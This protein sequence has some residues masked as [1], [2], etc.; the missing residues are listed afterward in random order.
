MVIALPKELRTTPEGKV[1]DNQG[2]QKAAEGSG[3]TA[4]EAYDYW[5]DIRRQDPYSRASEQ[6]SSTVLK[7]A[8]KVGV[9]DG[10]IVISAPQNVLD[11]PYVEQLSTQLKS[12]KGADLS[13][14]ETKNAIDALNKEIQANI[15]NAMIESSFGWDED[16]YK[17]YQYNLQ[18]LSVSNPLQSSNKI[19][20]YDKDN[21]IVM[22]TPQEWVDYYRSVYNTDERTDALYDSASSNDPYARTMFLV[23]TQGKD[24]PVY[25]W[26]FGEQFAQGTNAAWNQI[27]KLPE[28]L[29]RNLGTDTNT[30]DVEARAKDL[31]IPEEALKK[32]DVV[33]EA[34]FNERKEALKDKSWEELSDDDKAFL[35]LLGVSKQKDN[36]RKVDRDMMSE[37]YQDDVTKNLNNMSSDDVEV[38]K[39]AINGILSDNSFEDYR[40]TRNNYS[41]WSG[42]DE[43]LNKN[44]LRLA[45]NAVWSEASQG[46]GNMAG[47]IARFLWE[48]ALIRAATGGINVNAISDK[49]G[50]GIL[51][52]INKGL[53]KVGLPLASK[54][55][56]AIIRF[57]GNL[58]GTIPEDILQTSIDNVLTYN[59]DENKNLLNWDELSDDFKRTFVF[60]A[61]FNAA[62]AGMSAFKRARLAKQLAKQADLNATMDIDGIASDADDLARA[63][64]NGNQITTEDGV[65]SVTDADGNTTVFR[66]ITPEDVELTQKTL[67][68]MADETMDE[69]ARATDGVPRVEIDVETPDGTVKME[70]PD[71][72]PR[73]LSEALEID[74]EPTQAGVRHWHNR[75]LEAVM[76]QLEDNLNKFHDKFGDVQASDFDWVWYQTKQGLSPEQIIGTTDPA[77]G[78][79]V[80]KNT[81]N[82]IEWWGKQPFVK[83]L[84]MASREALSLDGD[85]NTLGYLPHTDYDPGNASFEEAISGQLWNKATGAS[86]LRDGEYVGYGGD[87]N[88]RYRTFASNMLW[89]AKNADVATAKLIEEAQM[90]GRDVTPELIDE[91][92]RAVSGEK[93]IQQK[94]V[95]A[96]SSKK[97]M[98]ALAS[99]SEDI[100]WSEID[101]NIEKQAKDSGLGKAYHDNYRDIYTNADTMEITHQR[102]GLVNSFD[103]L[104]N[105]MRNTVIGNGMSMYDWGGAD[106]VY[107]SKNAADI[108]NRFVREGGDF[109]GMLVDYVENHSHRTRKYAEAVVDKWMDKLGKIPGDLTK[110][111]VLQSLS[112]SMK[113][114]AMTRLKKWL[115]MAKY[116]NFNSSTKKMIDQFLFNHVQMDSIKTNPTIGQKITKALDQLTGLRYRALFYGNIKNALLQ[117]SELNRYFSAFKWGDVANMAKRLATDESFRARVDDYVDAVAPST[118][119]L[120]A[121]L[122][123]NFSNVADSMEVGENGV[124][125]RDLGKKMKT[126]A[127]AIGLG[128]IEA[129]ESFKN[130]MMIAGLVSEADRLELTGDEALRHIRKR[131][132]RVALAAD[133]MG[134]IGLASNPL[135]KTM[136][137]LQNFQIRELGMHLYNIKDAWNLGNSVP[138]KVINATNYLTK[139]FGAKL[140]T[141][142]ILARLGYSPAQTMG[143]DPFGLLDRYNTMDEEDMEWVDKQIAG[144]LLTPFFSGGMTS[145]IA[146]MYFMARQAYEDSHQR[147]VAEEAEQKLGSSWGLEMPEISFDDIV[148]GVTSFI[149][150]SV[151][152]NRFGQM[153]QM[154]DTGWAVSSTGNQMYSAPAD[155][156]NILLGY[157]FGRSATQNALQYNQNYGDNLLQTVGR[158]NPFR[159]YNEFD[160][161]DTKN[162]SDWFKGDENDLQQFN[163]GRI[164]FQQEKNNIL[165][166]YGS[167]I[168]NSYANDD[169]VAEAQNSMNQKLNELFDKVDRFVDAYEKK[170]GTMSPAMA[171]QIINLLNIGRG[172]TGETLE[173]RQAREL[174][175]Y[176][177]ALQRYSDI[178]FSPVGT[179]TGP[180]NFDENKE[181]KYQGSPQYRTA[182][183][184][185]YTLEDEAALVLKK[186][187]DKLK[188]VRDSIKD[189]LNAAYNDSDYNTVETIQREY[190]KE[191]DN[192][193]SPIIALYGNGIFESTDVV[194]Q[195]KDMLSTGTNT[196]S[197]NLI[198]SDQYRKDKYGKYRSM[199]LETVDVKKWAQQR[200][201]DDI[202]NNP[203]ARSYS[204][205]EEDLKEIKRLD[206]NGQKQRARA[207]ALQLLV[208]VESQRSSLNSSDYTWLKK[209]LNNEGDE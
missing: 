202:Y 146:D 52:T 7:Q 13:S 8:P 121:E 30:A 118:P 43:N 181:V 20:G 96:P 73:N 148:G 182:A 81:I 47:T 165:D 168:N 177:E 105:R 57:V 11:S 31:K 189:E 158:F 104:G 80:S 206:S 174:Q 186:A 92:K 39:E 70:T 77:T 41:D 117:T 98:E 99:D 56:E 58:V 66:N 111:K 5:Q 21:K 191:F 133:E 157:L 178:G 114:E 123:D 113:W 137:F 163:K 131:F 6:I 32:F 190:L 141:T 166:T 89:D 22:K 4:Q 38:S 12:L 154:M 180:S 183:S 54:G 156:L 2:F 51:Q 88:S 74:V 103:T 10:D 112:S 139:V 197:G 69:A 44:D 203:T 134:R 142:L 140:A 62:K 138:K 35:L 78:R 162:Y 209:Y 59:A 67:F 201:D 17:D 3:Y 61:M 49:I 164:Y 144:G 126:T 159:Q 9:E 129:A 195:I 65:V 94:V 188:E 145:L 102:G 149:P 153:N 71:Y 93:E 208:R 36:L 79:V 68:D 37:Y 18:T 82:A 199:P 24:H 101:K 86:V 97:L 207:K 28:G 15:T 50:K 160:P 91:A 83:D 176:S 167:V 53:G 29:F 125:F 34:K 106:I 1:F 26:D 193:V 100:D 196:R 122:Y 192:V 63:I 172:H 170:N 205:T 23:L 109:R 179:Y 42:Y 200:F 175:D 25:G 169:E 135:A 116:D 40:K 33:D 143:L 14:A 127:D 132:E 173:E 27:T 184:G 128:P 108:V 124:N 95:E 60:M 171:K 155:P 87:F 90:D 107:A 147:T 151:A 115:T 152:A 48:A 72:R 55:G 85:F 120:D 119:L 150:G 110:G 187:D 76:S 19:K 198:P 194:N 185:K 130:R 16:A 45:K 84:R 64:E 161:I 204:T 75:S 46:L 136:L